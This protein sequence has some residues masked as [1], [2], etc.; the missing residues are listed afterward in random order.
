MRVLITGVNGQL[1]QELCH[2]APDGVEISAFD[3]EGLDITD[4]L[5]VHALF[6]QVKP[7]FV[8][9][10]AA[11]TAVDEA[12]QEQTLAFAVNADGPRNLATACS[13][14]GA[15]LIHV[16]TDF[17]FDGKKST[18]YMAEDEANPLGVYGASKLEGERN[19]LTHYPDGSLI[20]RVGWLYSR[21]GQNFV[22]TMLRLMAERDELGVVADQIGT[23]THAAGLAQAIWQFAEESFTTGIY[24]WSDAG[25]ASWYDFAV[26]IM[27]EGVS[28]GKLEKAISI[29]PI[30]TSDYPTPAMRPQ[31][32]VLDKTSSWTHLDLKPL[33]WRV[34]LRQMLQQL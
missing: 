29:K 19:V 7:E 9:N 20:I 32:S 24:H 13:E 8:I 31:Y 28:A 10:A 14:H 23:P 1:G 6:D 4:N 16:S 34:A 30:R 5:T 26:A 15:R 33:H 27:E 11:Y 17:I 2:A 22:K 18:P 25:V 3:R 21:F 12:E